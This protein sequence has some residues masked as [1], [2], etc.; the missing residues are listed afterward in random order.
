MLDTCYS[1]LLRN[2]ALASGRPCGSTH[3]FDSHTDAILHLSS[4]SVQQELATIAHAV[5]TSTLDVERKH[6]YDRRTEA[7]TVTSVAK[8]SRDSFV[9][10]WRTFARAS[11][12]VSKSESVAKAANRKLR[13]ANAVSVAYEANPNLFPQAVGKLHWETRTLRQQ[14]RRRR[15]RTGRP[16]GS[17]TD[18][19]SVME[20]H[21]DEYRAEAKR[22]RVLARKTQAQAATSQVS[23]PT[24]NAAWVQWLDEHEDTWQE[25]I[26]AV[27]A[28]VRTAVNQ[29]IVPHADV[30]QKDPSVRLQ[31]RDKD[32]LLSWA[33]K[34]ADGWHALSVEGWRI[35]IFAVRTA[36]RVAAFA[37]A[38]TLTVM[39]CGFH[40]CMQGFCFGIAFPAMQMLAAMLVFSAY[41]PRSLLKLRAS[42]LQWTSLSALTPSWVHW[43]TSSL[44]GA[45]AMTSRSS[46]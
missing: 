37:P 21:G 46:V 33:G 4:P 45:G 28:G 17:T 2:E 32:V 39:R 8:A 30:P 40:G 29:R 14:R 11:G 44:H 10:Q 42:A 13:Y 41:T 24:S 43:R 31:P 25:A 9:R 20:E 38:L 1:A 26:R 34:L 16:S 27:K 23:W 35:V 36:G 7:P 5:E 22:R 15:L 18:F 12:T 6:N 19:Q 3:T